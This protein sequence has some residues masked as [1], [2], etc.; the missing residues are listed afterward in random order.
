MTSPTS[1]SQLEEV[2]EPVFEHMKVVQA[3]L[4]T[5]DAE[6]VESMARSQGLDPADLIR[7]RIIERVQTSS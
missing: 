7:T 1:R 5:E 3:R 4:S 2:T 6:A